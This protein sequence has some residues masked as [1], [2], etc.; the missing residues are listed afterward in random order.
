[1]RRSAGRHRKDPSLSI[2]TVLVAVGCGTG[3]YLTAMPL[4]AQ[5]STTVTVS[6]TAGLRSAVEGASAGT[7][8]R[9]RGGTYYPTS[10]LRAAASGRPGSRITLTAYGSETVRIDGSRLPAG[11]TLA[12]ISGSYWTV[13]GLRFQNSPARGLVVTSSTGG[14]FS[15]LATSGNGGSGFTLRGDRT[16]DNL[17]RNLDSYDNHDPAGRRDDADGLAVTSGSGSGNRVTGARLFNNAD[18][19]MDVWRWASPVTVERSW[20]FGNGKA[21]DGESGTGETGETGKTGETGNSRHG[22]GFVLAAAHNSAPHLL[23]SNAAWDNAAD[24]F[25][26]GSGSGAVSLD[27]NTAYAN[28]GT[29]FRFATGAARLTR[30]LAVADT[31]GPAELGAQ[32]V[33]SGNSWDAGVAAPSFGSGDAATAHAPRRAGGSLPATAFLGTDGGTIGATMR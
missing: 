29:G 17:I 9:V 32:A 16:V 30:N 20:A 28:R 10:T 3:V 19:G 14:I 5:A 2:A 15:N 18:D 31:G 33:S 23:R 6:T 7:V 8:I 11:S 26:G 13:S 24:G 27:R 25:T 4:Y 1:M 21:G 22:N 12:G